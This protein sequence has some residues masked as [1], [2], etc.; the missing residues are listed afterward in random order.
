M[1][2]FDKQITDD[3]IKDKIIKSANL[4][5]SNQ[6]IVSIKDLISLVFN[7]LECK[8][9]SNAFYMHLIR[10][11]YNK[12]KFSDDEFTTIV[13]Y[14]RIAI[15]KSKCVKLPNLKKLIYNFSQLRFLVV[16][17]PSSYG[18]SVKS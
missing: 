2:L 16:F 6:Q 3:E 18:A 9:T 10:K 7:D 15:V 11:E 4:D 12:L 1:H 8:I 13:S 14:L 17:T 5:S